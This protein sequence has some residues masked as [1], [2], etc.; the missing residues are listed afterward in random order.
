MSGK[1]RQSYDAVVIGGGPAGLSAALVLGRACRQVLLV[2]AGAGR[3]APASAIHGFLGNDGT[4]PSELRRI[5]RAQLQPYDVDVHDAT[6]TS[7]KKLE[8]GFE[9]TID[10][11]IVQCRTLIL[12]TGITD[13]LPEIPGAKTWWGRGVLLCPY[14]HGWEIR[15]Q[16]WAFMA[17]TEQLIDRATVLLGW[18]KDLTYLC[19]D[20]QLSPDQRSWLTEHAISIREE[21]ITAFEGD[22]TRFTGVT[23]AQGERL[24]CAAVFISSQFSQQSP[25]AIPLGCE[26]ETEGHIAGMVKTELNGV[27]PVLGLFIAGDAAS[28]GVTSVAS[29]ASEGMMAAV[30]AN[31]AMLK[32]DA[33]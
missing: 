19:G 28:V 4:S 8:V 23:F 20:V 3:N 12:A 13:K 31:M 2:D 11:A 33:S 16:P 32:A 25:L 26:L 17:P 10:Q 21:P 1:L 24:D 7:V 15:N 14:C 22:E 30:F 6:V 18:T 27:T 29:A 9:A 5:G